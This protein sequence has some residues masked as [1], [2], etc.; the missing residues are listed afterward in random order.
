MKEDDKVPVGGRRVATT[1][2][3]ASTF[4]AAT[5]AFAYVG[6]GAGISLLGALWAL[7][8]A[9]FAAVAFVILWPVRRMMKRRRAQRTERVGPL[10]HSVAT[11]PQDEPLAD[12]ERPV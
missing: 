1:L 11:R 10:G 4:V 8:A 3:F 6:P 7:A 2:V 5:P 12:P 9:V